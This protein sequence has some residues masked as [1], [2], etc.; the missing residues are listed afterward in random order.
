MTDNKKKLTKRGQRVLAI[1]LTALYV[2]LC[3]LIFIYIGKPFVKMLDEPGRFKEW[4]ASHGLWGYLIYFFMTVLQVFVALIPGEPFEIAAG[5]AFGAFWGTVLCMAGILVGQTI[6][7]FL[8]RKFGTK[9]L[10]LF[11]PDSKSFTEKLAKNSRRSVKLLFILFFIP[12]TPKD[13]LCYA[14][15]LTT[16]PYSQFI[17]VTAFARLATVVSSTV[18]GNAFS[19]GRYLFGIIVFAVTALISIAG[20]IIYGKIKAKIDERKNDTKEKTVE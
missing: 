4:I 1:L 10:D 13:V 2:G 7:F 18:G 16:I 8:I 6:V 9:I 12:G 20:L 15:G 14:A 3:A 19:E 5:Y 17:T 11:F